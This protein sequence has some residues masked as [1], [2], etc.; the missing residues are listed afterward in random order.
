VTTLVIKIDT[1]KNKE[2]YN[3]VL[4]ALSDYD[5]VSAAWETDEPAKQAPA[6]VR[7]ARSGSDLGTA[8]SAAIKL[9]SENQRNRG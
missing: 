8:V 1:E 7:S 5:V 6:E 4:T 9:L 3:G 2:N